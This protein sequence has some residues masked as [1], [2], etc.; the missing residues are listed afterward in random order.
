MKFTE[1]PLAGAFLLELDRFEDERGTFARTFC[2]NELADRGLDPEVAQCNVSIN[3]HRHTLRG[4]HYQES[5]HGETKLIRCAVGAIYD[6]IVDLRP[7]SPT[8][9]RWYAHTLTGET[10]DALYVPKSFAHGFL[11]LSDS[12]TVLYQ[13]STDYQPAAARGVRWDDPSLG[14]EWPSIPNVISERD[15]SYPLLSKGER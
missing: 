5:P 10:F 6:V 4:L 8:Y 1:T 9:R 11:S 12:S 13:M 7:A 3:P 15:A 14:I 2:R